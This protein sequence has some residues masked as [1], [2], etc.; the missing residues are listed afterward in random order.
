LCDILQ[1]VLPHII[2]G[3]KIKW[4]SYRP[5]LNFSAFAMLSSWLC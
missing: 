1:V 5:C 4:R 2:L 3:N